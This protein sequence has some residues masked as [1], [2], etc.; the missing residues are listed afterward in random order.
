MPYNSDV[1]DTDWGVPH[2][3][4]FHSTAAPGPTAQHNEVDG[5]DMPYNSDVPDTD[6]G[7]SHDVPFH[8]TASPV[9]EPLYPTAQHSVVDG[10][11]MPFNVAVLEY[12]AVLHV[13]PSHST[14]SPALLLVPPTA[15]HN[16]VDGHDMPSNS[17]APDTG[18]AVVPLSV[19]LTSLGGGMVA[20][21]YEVDCADVCACQSAKA[22]GANIT[23]SANVSQKHTKI[24]YSF[25]FFMLKPPWFF[26]E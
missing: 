5:Q 13:D 20:V 6:W 2:D 10:Q 25:I 16:V 21:L 22:F 11:D 24:G 1:P 4:P 17:D 15:Q 7:V 12:C 18:V 14:T 26:Y 8:S 19:P 23:T 9:A 3:V